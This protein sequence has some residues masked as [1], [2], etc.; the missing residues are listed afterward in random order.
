MPETYQPFAVTLEM[1]SSEHR[2]LKKYMLGVALNLMRER[3]CVAI[4]N[5]AIYG[6]KGSAHT[7]WLFLANYIQQLGIKAVYYDRNVWM[8]MQEDKLGN[9]K[10][11]H[12]DDYKVVAKNPKVW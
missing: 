5:K 9:D 8:W 4:I 11:T 10:C 3:G 7:F 12:I 1:P 6:L 2:L